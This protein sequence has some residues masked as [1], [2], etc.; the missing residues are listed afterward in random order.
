MR[1]GLLSAILRAPHANGGV[2]GVCV[3]GGGGRLPDTQTCQFVFHKFT[4]EDEE[5]WCA[6]CHSVNLASLYRILDVKRTNGTSDF[7]KD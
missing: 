1:D 5:I 6:S 3:C 4:N 7:T 2:I